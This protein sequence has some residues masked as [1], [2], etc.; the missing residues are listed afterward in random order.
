[1]AS[2][3]FALLLLFCIMFMHASSDN[4]HG[5]GFFHVHAVPNRKMNMRM[6]LGRS[7]E[8]LKIRNEMKGKTKKGLYEELRN[9]P[10]GPDPLHHNGNPP[11]KP[12]A[13]P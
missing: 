8:A 13:I 4:A 2:R 12:K 9:V 6:E 1:M 7:N 10:S 5:H 3:S 11:K